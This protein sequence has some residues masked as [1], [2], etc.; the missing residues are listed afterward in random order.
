MK[1]HHLWEF[2]CAVRTDVTQKNDFK[3][4]KK[5]NLKKAT[6][7]TINRKCHEITKN[8]D[9]PKE[10]TSILNKIRLQNRKGLIIAYLNIN[11]IRNKFEQ[12]ELLVSKNIDILIVAETKLDDTFPTGQF[13]LPGFKVPFRLDRNKNGGGILAYI[14]EEVPSKNLS[15]FNYPKDIE[16]V[17]IEINL[18]RSK[19]VLFG[20]YRPPCQNETYFLEEIGKAID[21]YSPNY[22]NFVVIGDFNFEEN[23][24]KL[25]DFSTS[26]G[27]KNL[28]RNP[29]CFK[30]SDNP[31]TID[32]I[33]TNKRGS[34]TGSSTFE[35]GLS[36]FH[37]MIFTVLKGGFVKKGPKTVYYR[38]FSKYDNKAFERDL[39]ENLSNR[40]RSKFEYGAFDKIVDNVL[41]DH[42]PL[43]K[44]TVRAN[45][46]PFMTKPLRKAIM[47]RTRLRNRY[48]KLRT[49]ENWRAFKKQR[50]RPVAARP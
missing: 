32:L 13:L 11:S 49:D 43:K 27:L 39:Q 34:F 30:S 45:D 31:R 5:V 36:D 23:N 41:N 37:V 10:E 18:H 35:T 19:W 7:A 33:L 29:T 16:C 28:I 25:S 46:S 42:A 8:A 2:F 4:G 20:I 21:H 15:E 12:L 22:E 26:Y 3:S 24:S 14:R 50:N 48:N 38:D 40:D 1:A 17:T 47:T 44:K 6:L 9:T